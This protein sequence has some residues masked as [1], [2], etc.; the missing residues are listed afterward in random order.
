MS[1][2]LGFSEPVDWYKEDQ[3]QI[4]ATRELYSMLEALLSSGF[5]VDLVD[6]WEGA[7]PS[8]IVTSEVSFDDVSSTTFRLFENHRFRLRKGSVTRQPTPGPVSEN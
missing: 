8:D 2:D 7:Q 1:L 4:D 6:R 3:D 5:D